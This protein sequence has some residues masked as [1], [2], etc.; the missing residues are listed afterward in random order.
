MSSDRSSRS[1]TIENYRTLFLKH[2]QGPAVGQ[3]SEEVQRFRFEKLSEILDLRD[4][5]I[6]DLGCGLGDF[7]PYLKRKFRALDYTGIDIVPEIIAS[8]RGIHP[9]A[10]FHCRDVLVDGFD[11]PFDYVLISGMFNNRISEGTEFL[12]QMVSFAFTHCKKEVGFNFTSTYVNFMDSGMQ[13]HD[14]FE[15]FRH[16]LNLTPKVSFFHHYN[17]CDVAVFACR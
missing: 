6:H 12:K 9:D 7:Y 3:W 2:G 15:V 5:K 8:A 10:I 17:R 13:Y 1:D 4:K 11:E 14:P 16:C